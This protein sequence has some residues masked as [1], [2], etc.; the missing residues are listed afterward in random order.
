MVISDVDIKKEMK[1]EKKNRR[2]KI[3]FPIQHNNSKLI[4]IYL[5][6]LESTIK[7]LVWENG[8]VL[9]LWKQENVWSTEHK[10]KYLEYIFS[11]GQ[12]FLPIR[13]GHP[14]PQY[15]NYGI[16][17]DTIMYPYKSYNARIE[18]EKNK[19]IN[20]VP[21]VL[22]DGINR[23]DA[24]LEFMAN[25]LPVYGLKRFELEEKLDYDIESFFDDQDITITLQTEFISSIKEVQELREKINYNR[26]NE[27]AK[28]NR[29]NRK[30]QFPWKD[31]PNSELPRIIQSWIIRGKVISGTEIEFKCPKCGK[32]L[33]I[34]IGP[35]GYFLECSNYPSC[36]YKKTYEEE[37][38]GYMS[39]FDEDLYEFTDEPF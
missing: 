29:Y 21:F 8:L 12:E 10:T 23:L 17:D 15:P 25:E 31:I 24:W 18:A 28:L 27:K 30:E 13:L 36:K 20:F 14:D 6:Y 7:D 4:K 16:D 35:Y 9:R 5:P 39:S 37:P 19:N 22:I 26:L 38:I 3:P 33:S 2:K 11:G 32:P 1:A 34:K